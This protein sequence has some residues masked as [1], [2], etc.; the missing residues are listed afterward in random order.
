M[1]SKFTRRLAC[2][3]L[4][5]WLAL[6][7]VHAADPAASMVAT[8]AW[9]RATPGS[10]KVAGGY[11][12]IE[13]RGLSADRLL[14]ASTE[15]ARKIEIH[16]MAVSEGIMTMRLVEG[17]LLVEP[18][19]IVKLAPG[20]LHL[21]I[22]GLSVPLVEGDKVPVMLKFEKAGDV[23]VSFDVRAMGAPAPGPLSKAADP[24][25]VA[26]VKVPDD[27]F[28]IHLHDERAMANVTISA[29]HDGAVEIAIQ[30]ETVEEL[31]LKAESVSV[32]LG[33][34]DKGVVPVTT[35]AQRTADDQWSVKMP[36]S[37]PG[38]WN[39]GLG[40]TLAPANTVS[41]ASP[42]LIY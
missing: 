39:L 42:I 12:T 41:I 29:V 2:A 30:L 1:M 14:S 9:S 7:A 5:S 11:L 21:M 23:S 33:N 36:A 31:P 10:S 3:A 22:I 6:P 35:Q 28:F 8:Q 24:A 19:R 38:R 37:G 13:N 20:G 15:V 27:S 17:G 18:G 25:V 4:L 16:E 26:A 34:P 32:T 40:I